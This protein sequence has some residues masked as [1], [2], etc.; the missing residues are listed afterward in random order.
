MLFITGTIASP[1]KPKTTQEPSE[2]LVSSVVQSISFELVSTTDATTTVAEILS[3]TTA[4]IAATS[5]GITSTDVTSTAEISQVTSEALTRA[6]TQTSVDITALTTVTTET[7]SDTTTWI[8]LTTEAT[9]DTT[10]WFTETS[11]VETTTTAEAPPSVT[12]FSLRAS[13]S[14]F[15]SANGKWV[16]QHASEGIRLGPDPNLEDGFEIIDF[17]IEPVTNYLKVDD[18]YVVASEST[19]GIGFYESNSVSRYIVCTPPVA[20]GE[21][22][23]C[24]D[25]FGDWYS[26]AVDS[27]NGLFLRY[28][29][30]NEFY[31]PVDLIVS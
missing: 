6:S 1:C 18:S 24:H 22:L 29:I 9:A 19:S 21:K 10:T 17:S 13:N 2:S 4:G 16:V 31:S 11:T 5:T 12:T 3:S 20:K 27:T 8:T 26:W 23:S 25:M 28:D 7:T 15:T 14:G 30:A